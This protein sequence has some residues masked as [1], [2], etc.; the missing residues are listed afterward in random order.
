LSGSVNEEEEDFWREEDQLIL[1]DLGGR[2]GIRERRRSSV[3]EH[4]LAEC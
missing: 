3:S 1:G 2:R 4:S